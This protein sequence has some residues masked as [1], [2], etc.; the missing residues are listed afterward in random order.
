MLLVTTVNVYV[1][2]I[3]FQHCIICKARDNSYLRFASEIIHFSLLYH[4]GLT[5]VNKR[6]QPIKIDHSHG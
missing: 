3:L 6:K 2:I 1:Q 4:N 5:R